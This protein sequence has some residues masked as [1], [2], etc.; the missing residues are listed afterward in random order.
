[1]IREDSAVEIYLQELRVQL[2]DLPYGDASDLVE[3]IAEEL[4]A[5]P[6]REV[7]A[8][9]AA[10]GSPAQIA[11]ELRRESADGPLDERPSGA[12]TTY[13]VGTS[14]AVAFGGI[15]VPC[16]GWIA[17]VVLMWASPV[18]GRTQKWLTTLAPAVLIVLAFALVVVLTWFASDP[19][20]SNGLVVSGSGWTPPGVEDYF[21]DGGPNPLVPASYDLWWSAFVMSYAAG[22][23]A[24]FCSGVVLL[25]RGLRRARN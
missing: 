18:W 21:P 11:A 16:L 17:G 1:M 8:R 24:A 20:S 7:G 15:L 23:I 25:V 12:S 10:L 4:R 5:L 14:L 2:R 13:V 6:E 3:G 22:S 9:I 19:D